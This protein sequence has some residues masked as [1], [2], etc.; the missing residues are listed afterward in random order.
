MSQS[1]IEEDFE[2]DFDGTWT[3]TQ[4]DKRAEY[5]KGLE[6]LDSS[7]AVDFAGVRARTLALIEMKDFRGTRIENKPRT[8]AELYTEVALKV[9]DSIAGFVGAVRMAEHAEDLVAIGKACV[10]A[11]RVEI[12]LWLAISNRP[13]ARE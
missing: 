3:V 10:T 13:T 12:I 8:E 9:R 4:W 11:K 2:V 6:T 1:F 7:K 5:R